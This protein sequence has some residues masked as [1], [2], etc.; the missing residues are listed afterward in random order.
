[1][2]LSTSIWS[3]LADDATLTADLGTYGGEPAV[4]VAD[5]DTVPEDYPLPFVVVA[6]P[7]YDEPNDTK[8]EDGRE[9]EILI[10]AY[11]DATGD[12]STVETIAERIRAL[13]HRQPVGLV[14]GAYIVR[15]SGPVV[16]PTDAS[17]Y[18]REIA[19]RVTSLSDPE[20]ES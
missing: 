1:M 7:D 20:E 16:T 6:G 9:Q 5:E 2:S 10:R 13:L 17:L 14:D 8:A 18:G 4:I 19:V 11:T 15:C 3:R 12:T